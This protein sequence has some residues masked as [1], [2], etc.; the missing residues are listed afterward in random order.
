MLVCSAPLWAQTVVGEVAIKAPMAKARVTLHDSAG[1]TRTAE[2]TSQGR[3]E[4][5]ANGLIPPL[6]IWASEDGNSNCRRTN[7]LRA[8]CLTAVLLA[9]ND[10][11]NIANLNPLT[12]FVA[13]EVAVALGFV[14]PQ[15]LSELARTPDVTSDVYLNALQ[16]MHAG[17]DT[18]LAQAG[19]E[20]PATFN[21][22]TTNSTIERDAMHRVLNVINHN[23]GYDNNSGEAAATVITDMGWRPIVKPF[24]PDANEPLQWDRS[25]REL[26]R[27]LSA[28]IRVFIVG[29]ST[30]ATYERQRLPRMGWGQVFQDAFHF[31]S[32]VVV[33]N[34]ARA[35]RSSRDFLHGGWY[36]QM[37]PFMQ[38]GD[39]V[40]IGHGH[41]DQNCNSHRDKRGA[42]DVA[43][44]C[45][46]P[47]SAAGLRQFPIGH[48]SMS[49]QS[50]LETYVNDARSRGATPILLTPTTRFLNE[51]R[52]Q[53]FK[54]GDARPV[55]SQH[56]TRQNPSGGYAFVGNYAQ[57]IKD[58]A[59]QNSVA[60][61]DLESKT[62][63]FA[64]AHALDWQDYWLVVSDTR[65]YPWYATQKEGSP[66]MP[67]TTHFQENGAR[68]IATMLTHGIREIPA[69]RTLSLHLKN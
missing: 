20:T 61:I 49:F 69:L 27:I 28:R 62:I 43:N 3:Y 2:T 52:K 34:G 29:D 30:A 44:L 24:G 21:P 15:Q 41:N 18:A 58:T 46:Y 55:V 57:T 65:K 53:A 25:K 37:A 9:L 6:A 4:I 64:N 39:Y 50:S 31:D 1:A 36:R 68:A 10:G 11:N 63:G 38:P 7:T 67:D 54:N 33:I 12:D 17:F 19:I 48:E 56:L 5:D 32:G 42:A 51:A 14:G 13:S 26:E 23:R 22:M 45:T 8:Q 66:T 35:G 16:V 59:F 40:L 47:N 60:L